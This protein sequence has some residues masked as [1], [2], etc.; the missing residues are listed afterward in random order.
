MGVALINIHER[1]SGKRLRS[2]IN[3][4]CLTAKNMNQSFAAIEYL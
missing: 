2:K 3:Q 1:L 4:T